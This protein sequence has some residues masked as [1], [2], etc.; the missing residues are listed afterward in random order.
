MI[1]VYR[2]VLENGLTIVVQ[3]M[4]GLQ[5]AALQAWVGVGSAD[6]TPREAG[7]AH[8]H[9][10]MLFKGTKRRKVGEIAQTIEGAG[11]EIN[12]W[13]SLDQTV[14]HV[15]V[16][17]RFFDVALDVLADALQH[18][19]FDAGELA[20]E[21]EVVL[22]EIKRGEDQPGRVASQ[23]VF[24]LA[25]TVHPYRNPVI[26]TPETV[27]AHTRDDVLSF[28]RRWYVPENIAVVIAGDVS[29]ERA[30]D[31]V[32]RA[33]GEFARSPLPPR[34]GVRETVQTS[35]RARV[36]REPFEEAHFNI[37][38]HGPAV[39]H[40]DVPA[41]DLF[42]AILGQGESARLT[43]EVKR[44]RGLVND[45]YAYAYTPKDPG[46]LLI[47]GSTSA[48]RVRQA[49]R[50]VLEEA[51]RLTRETVRDEEL[52]KAR[53]LI[54]SQA[55]YDKET[56][57][58]MA[59]K[60]GFYESALRD[61]SFEERY[62]EAIAKATPHDLLEVARKYL[63]A[64]RLCFAVVQPEKA[65]ARL[66]D[67]DLLTLAA[68]HAR[69]PKERRVR[70]ARVRVART[71]LPSG[72]T[73]LVRRDDRV[74]LVALR[75]VWRGGLRYERPHSGGIT[76]F[77]AEV[78]TQGTLRRSAAEVAHEVDAMA[79]SL[80]GFSGRNSFGLRGEFLSRHFD[81]ALELFA[82]CL[83][84]PA[85]GEPE[86]ER[87][88]ALQLEEIR[89]L[90]DNPAGVAFRMLAQALY[91]RHP[92]RL[93]TLGTAESV[94]RFTRADLVRAYRRFYP[95]PRA[96]LA[97]VGDID[98][99]RVA[100]RAAK[101]LAAAPGIRAE[102]VEPEPDPPLG[103]PIIVEETREKRQAHIVLG[104]RGTTLYSEDRYPL[105]VLSTILSGQG[106]R[107]FLE[108]RD[109]QSLAYS[110]SSVSV[111]GLE[112]GY[113]AVYIG[114][115]PEKI[116][117]AVDGILAELDRV[118]QRKVSA[119]ELRRA[120]RYL[121]GTHEISLQ[122]FSARAAVLAFDECYGLGYDYS[123]KYPQ[124][125]LS[126]TRDAVL[127]AARRTLDLDRYVLAIV[128]PSAA[129]SVG[130]LD[131]AARAAQIGTGNDAR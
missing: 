19:T 66:V 29:V 51:F 52:A 95:L 98:P 70:P 126:V 47:G 71:Q 35:P 27:A 89:N 3:E 31:R 6:E 24:R 21:K 92:Y 37:A 60:L 57:Q 93:H 38:V 4:R 39:D 36:R 11:G 82:E 105:E 116:R 86:V 42:T 109:R 81:R 50:A 90:D 63:H 85:F 25:Y 61:L 30:M 7:L 15:V 119:E 26:G 41:L 64:D 88:R 28:Y 49:I 12:A 43:Q 131:L 84:L 104:F 107:L 129:P 55:T 77:L 94:R 103:A 121:V 9:E 68:N 48:G 45:V 99:T 100:D 111:E 18:S 114:T 22:E 62:Y 124:R 53:A 102:P 79:G 123:D 74:G 73:L 128:R 76:H 56:A 46:L 32:R 34:H 20:R 113:F 33:F 75:A 17:S 58:G 40:P 80:A 13:T 91:Q 44:R 117:Q 87:Q 67:E 14:Y 106:G 16:A 96:V 97:V 110:V 2:E 101:V 65:R 23:E 127:D 122:R 120:Q 108:L 59:R 83:L 78:L 10:H 54:E 72:T 130:S 118:R 1:P 112:P 69:P 5:V 115:S 125:I 8:L